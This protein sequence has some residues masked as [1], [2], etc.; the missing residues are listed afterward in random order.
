[1][2]VT[3]RSTAVSLMK[4]DS[5]GEKPPKGNWLV[6]VLGVEDHPVRGGGFFSDAVLAEGFGRVKFH[7]RA[8]G[9]GQRRCGQK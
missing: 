5:V 4:A 9:Q 1:M 3:A 2:A 8:R 7:P 6:A